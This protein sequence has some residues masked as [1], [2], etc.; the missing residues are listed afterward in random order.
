MYMPREGKDKGNKV[1]TFS[2][3]FIDSSMLISFQTV[4]GLPL[5]KVL[6]NVNNH[7]FLV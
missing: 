5:S 4:E 1:Q 7:M 3:F 2:L 6:K